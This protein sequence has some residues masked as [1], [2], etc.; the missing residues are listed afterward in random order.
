MT[1]LIT[2]V[3]YWGVGLPIGY[4]LGLTD[5]LGTAQ[6]PAGMWQGLIAGLTCAAVLLGL[7]LRHISNKQIVQLQA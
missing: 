4:I 6:G 2:L 3:S 5:Y 1:M 7:R